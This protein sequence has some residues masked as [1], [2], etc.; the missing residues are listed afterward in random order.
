ML[1]IYRADDNIVKSDDEF[2]ASPLFVFLEITDLAGQ[3]VL[4]H[5]ACCDLFAFCMHTRQTALL[6]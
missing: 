6:L 5:P 1:T 2:P 4:L 3:D